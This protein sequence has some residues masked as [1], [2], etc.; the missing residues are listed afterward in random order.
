MNI[1]NVY[2]ASICKLIDINSFNG[3]K[4]Y[5]YVHLRNTL[6]L[7]QKNNSYRDLLKKKQVKNNFRTCNI[8]DEFIN[9]MQRFEPITKYFNNTLKQNISKRKVMK[10]IKTYS[11]NK[12]EK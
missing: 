3:K 2:I 4:I 7:K 12:E 8:E 10:L 11:K 1:N 6:V 9:Y 5:D